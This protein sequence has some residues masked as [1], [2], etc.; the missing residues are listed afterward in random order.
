MA[1]AMMTL[2]RVTPIVQPAKPCAS[3]AAAGRDHLESARL[4]AAGQRHGS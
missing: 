4:R 2:M 1:P 3:R